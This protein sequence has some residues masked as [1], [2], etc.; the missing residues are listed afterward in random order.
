MPYSEWEK[1]TNGFKCKCGS[2][3]IRFQIWESSDGAYE[4]INYHCDDCG[5]DWWVD[6]CDS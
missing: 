6:G 2:T 4:D 5:N 1:V 3:N